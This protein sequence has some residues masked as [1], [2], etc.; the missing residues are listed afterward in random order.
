M[1]LVFQVPLRIPERR[2]RGGYFLESAFMM[3]KAMP[4]SACLLSATR[5]AVPQSA[6]ARSVQAD[7]GVD[8][9]QLGVTEPHGPMSNLPSDFTDLEIDP[10]AAI[11]CTV[12]HY[13]VTDKG[14]ISEADVAEVRH[15]MDKIYGAAKVEGSLVVDANADKRSTAPK[16]RWL[17][18]PHLG[19]GLWFLYPAP[20]LATAKR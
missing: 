9:A 18:K 11:R 15:T 17:N 19:S 13:L 10:N 3:P 14:S 16:N 20:V 8:H 5:C 6:R 12:Q 7:L 4:A 1:L 2:G